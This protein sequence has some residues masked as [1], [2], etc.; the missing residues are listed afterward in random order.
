[1]NQ[2]LKQKRKMMKIM[3]E[4]EKRVEMIVSWIDGDPSLEYDDDDDNDKACIYSG[5]HG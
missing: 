5:L 2:Q 3:K 4:R 1:M